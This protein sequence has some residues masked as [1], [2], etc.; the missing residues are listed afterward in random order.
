MREQLQA[1]GEHHQHH[2][3]PTRLG[4]LFGLFEIRLEAINQKAFLV[5]QMLKRSVPL[6]QPL[7]L[8]SLPECKL[9]EL[10]FDHAT[11]QDC[12]TVALFPS[13]SML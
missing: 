1:R 7:E 9:R 5:G 10:L 4:L 3:W 2:D 13:G 11:R 12:T 6:D 8:Q